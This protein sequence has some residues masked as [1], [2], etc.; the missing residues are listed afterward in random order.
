MIFA[1]IPRWAYAVVI[2]FLLTAAGGSYVMWKKTEADF[3]KF[4]A[5]VAEAGQ[6]AEEA[7]RKRERELNGKLQKAQNESRQREQT[8]RAAADLARSERDGLRN[9]ID[10]GGRDLSDAPRAAIIERATTLGALLDQ[11]ATAFEGLAG[12][13]DR[14][15]S[16]AR[17]L[18]DGWPK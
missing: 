12:K 14:H 6:K 15:A 10:A 9:A 17:L 13:A 8:L 11:C 2:G 3:A 4:R 18:L 16:D 5:D 7:N 1:L